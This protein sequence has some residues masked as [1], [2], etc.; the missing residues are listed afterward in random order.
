MEHAAEHLADLGIEGG[1]FAVL[2]DSDVTALAGKAQRGVSLAVFAI[3][4]GQLAG[5]RG[6]AG[7]W[8]TP[9]MPDPYQP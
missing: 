7:R 2:L 9:W 1:E 4:V 6:S 3:A 5:V 8:V